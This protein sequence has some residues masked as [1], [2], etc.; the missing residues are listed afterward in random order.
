MS[1]EAEALD[2]LSA[3]VLCCEAVSW[4]RPVWGFILLRLGEGTQSL[5][6]AHTRTERRRLLNLLLPDCTSDGERLW[7]TYRRPFCWLAEGPLRPVWRAIGDDFANF[8]RSEECLE[9]AKAVA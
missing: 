8:L 4:L 9:L 7:G 1:S 3:C 6:P 2:R 5:W